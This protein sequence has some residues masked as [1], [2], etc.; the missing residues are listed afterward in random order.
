[1]DYEDCPLLLAVF[2]VKTK[3]QIGSGDEVIT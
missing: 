1:M 3:A 2:A